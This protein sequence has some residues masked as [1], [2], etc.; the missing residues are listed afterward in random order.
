MIA[1]FASGFE[2]LK[3]GGNSFLNFCDINI[4]PGRQTSDMNSEWVTVAPKRQKF[5]TE[6]PIKADTTGPY[7]IPILNL[8]VWNFPRVWSFSC[9]AACLNSTA[10]VPIFSYWATLINPDT[11]M[12][13]W[14]VLMDTTLFFLLR[15]SNTANV[16]S[17]SL[18]IFLGYIRDL[19][20][21]SLNS[22]IEACKM[23]TFECK[24]GVFCSTKDPF[25]S[26]GMPS[27]R[28]TWLSLQVLR[29][30]R[31]KRKGQL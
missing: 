4:F 11:T 12:Y 19:V 22:S 24:L 30:L 13:P 15:W 27:S 25:N 6:C 28:L 29:N 5:G 20:P 23:T 18:I 9:V 8:I 2:Y 16:S 26:L 31:S 14:F 3:V 7:V 1:V 10:K 21:M 17:I